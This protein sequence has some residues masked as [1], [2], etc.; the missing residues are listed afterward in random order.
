MGLALLALWPGSAIAQKSQQPTQPTSSPSSARP[1]DA[2]RPSPVLVSPE[3][4]YRIGV[5]DVIEVQVEDMPEVSR[6]IRVTAAGTFLMPVLGRMKAQGKTPE[7]LAE[8]IADKLRG[9]Y[10]KDPKVSVVIKE[11]NSRS[12]FIQ[13]AVRNPG[14]FQI[15][16]KPS[17]LTLI[18]LAGGLAENHGSVSFII[19][20]AKQQTGVMVQTKSEGE[21]TTPTSSAAIQS[22]TAGNE[23]AAAAN[24]EEEEPKYELLRANI[25]SLLRGNFGNNAL[26]QPGDIVN[27]PPLDVFYVAG[28]VKAPGSF[29]LKE[30]TTLRQAVSL[31]Q[32]TNYNAALEHA[33]IF[34]DDANGNRQ[35]IPVDIGAVMKGKKEDV[36]IMANDIIIVPN[37]RMK[38]FGGALIKAFGLTTITR[39]PIP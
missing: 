9:D 36:P 38:S 37:S 30:G 23:A 28:E 25:S 27:I 24:V 3:E 4:D 7:G 21:S 35:E 39:M 8:E 11:Y 29:S 20:R 31:A 17:L 34:R 26:L 16:G 1:P 32:G 22:G 2:F 14:V 33:L 6:S 12:F 19:R 5:G 10:L 13:G 18:T 15:E